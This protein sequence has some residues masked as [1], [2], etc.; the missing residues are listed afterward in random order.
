MRPSTLQSLANDLD[1]VYRVVVVYHLT[2]FY[3]ISLGTGPCPAHEAGSCYLPLVED[4]LHVCKLSGVVAR[5]VKPFVADAG[6][7]TL[8]LVAGHAMPHHAEAAQP[9]DLH[10]NQAAQHLAFVTLHLWFWLLVA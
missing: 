1:E 2:E 3:Y 4:N 6:G 10:V 7:K 9:L 8:L 5:H